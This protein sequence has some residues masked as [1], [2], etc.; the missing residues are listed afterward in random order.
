MGRKNCSVGFIIARGRTPRNHWNATGEV[1]PRVYPEI[2]RL[3]S[4]F[5]WHSIGLNLF[6]TI[7]ISVIDHDSVE[8]GSNIETERSVGQEEERAIFDGAPDLFMSGQWVVRSHRPSEN[9]VLSGVS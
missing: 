7:S 4:T 2:A 1:E 3:S 5:H 9:L 8:D 6:S